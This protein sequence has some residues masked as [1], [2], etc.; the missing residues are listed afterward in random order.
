MRRS[1]YLIGSS[2]LLL[3][4]ACG[5]SKPSATPSPLVARTTASPATLDSLWLRA[6]D[7]YGR[8]KWSKAATAFERLQLE[9]PLGDRRQILSRFYLAETRV[10][11]HSNLQAVREFRRVSDE[12]PTDSMAPIA[13]LR[14]GDSYAALWR[15]PELDPTYGQTA[16]ATYQELISRYPASDAAKRAQD[17][18]TELEERFAIKTFQAAKFY[19]RF[20]ATD[21]AIL[22][23]KDLLATWPRAKI[24]PEALTELVLAYRSLGYTEDVREY[25]GILR[26]RFPSAPKIDETCPATAPAGTPA[27][28]PA[29]Q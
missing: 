29:G 11:E 5:K 25:C 15:R 14:A 2:L 28:K 20:K 21:S 9:L 3:V 23:L 1:L 8:K 26:T 7:L 24:A 27:E 12:F 13:L 6:I 22:Y 18:I 10:G 4:A 16:I 19:L 17:K